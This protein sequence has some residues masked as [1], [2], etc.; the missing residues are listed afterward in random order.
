MDA[1][2]NKIT[3]DIFA[4]IFRQDLKFGKNRNCH[5]LEWLSI[6]TEE[7]G[8]V[9]RE[10]NDAGFSQDK[11]TDNYRNE[12]IQ[13]AAVAMQ[14]VLN[15]DRQDMDTCIWCDE[16]FDY[17]EMVQDDAGENY[18]QQCW[19]EAE[20]ILKADYEEAV[21]DGSID[22]LEENGYSFETGV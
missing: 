19:T 2:F 8:E 5:P 4:E 16:K 22:Q 14:A 20:P 10:I 18:C 12:L 11:L 7:T 3:E 15:F 6:L 1:R 9:A 17:K 21:R 13:V